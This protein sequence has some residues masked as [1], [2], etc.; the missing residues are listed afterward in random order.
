MSKPIHIVATLGTILDSQLS[1]ES[2]KFQL[3]RWSHKVV[4]FPERTTHPTATHPPYGFFSWI[5]CVLSLGCHCDVSRVFEGCLR[6]V[7]KISRMCLEVV[8]RLSGWAVEGA[9]WVSGSLDIS[10]EVSS[11]K[12]FWSK[13]FWDLILHY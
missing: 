8:S 10:V 9:W 5:Y 12:S 3:A 11:K 7:R 6:N 13:I 4:I 1:W 2:C